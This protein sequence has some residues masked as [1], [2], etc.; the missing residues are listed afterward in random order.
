MV[1]SRSFAFTLNNYIDE[2]LESIR[3]IEGYRY[4]VLGKEVGESGTPHIQ[5]T[6]YFKSARSFDSIKTKI[7]RAHIEV[8]RDLFRSITYC[9]KDGNYEELGDMPSNQRRSAE[10]RLLERAEKNQRLL[11]P[12]TPIVDLVN[13]GELSAYSVGSIKKARMVIAQEQV[14]Y[15]HTDVRGQW[16][17][18]PPGTGKSRQARELYPEAYIKAQ[19]KWFDGYTGEKAI[20]L[21]D[22]DTDTLGHL[23]KIWTD[24]YACSGEIKGG[25]V[26][27]V[28]SVFVVTSNYTIEQLFKE[29]IL[30]GAIKRRFHV[31]HFRPALI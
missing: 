28:H 27:L 22:L 12:A 20:I 3:C 23:L 15:S 30:V 8:C 13:S 29:P 10:E 26:N 5:G 18:G 6:I 9:K 31:T 7:P 4:M 16:Y 2:E 1:R 11:D 24:R 17:V 14:K 21:D 25:I 19:N